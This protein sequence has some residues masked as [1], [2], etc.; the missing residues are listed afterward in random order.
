MLYLGLVFG[1]AAGDIAAHKAGLNAIR[2]YIATLILIVAALSGSR[3]LYVAVQWK[4]YR[5]NLRR[6]LDRHDGGHVMYGGLLGALLV[7]IPLLWALDLNFGAFWDVSSFTILVG[8]MFTRI[9]CLLNGCC[10]G[11]PSHSWFSVYL[12]NSRGEW[13]K[14][15]PTQALEAA[16]AV[17][18]LIFI[19]LIW[20][21]MP[22]PSALFL[23]ATLGYSAARFTMEFARGR[24]PGSSTFRVAHVISV[25]AFVSSVCTLTLYWHK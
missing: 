12:P 22:F 3:L 21:W 17:F 9:G 24:E 1:V 8:M 16:C 18:L 10:Y 23:C 13:E 19:A 14:R 11:R 6:I 4:I 2:W 7:S 15:I 20:R 5:H 25:V